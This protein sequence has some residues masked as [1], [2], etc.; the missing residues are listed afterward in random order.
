[1]GAVYRAEQLPLARVCA[2]KVLDPSATRAR[3]LDPAFRRRFLR[4]AAILARLKHP[5]T[6]TLF[7]YGCDGGLCFIAMELVE[8]RTLLELLRSE[9]ALSE[10]RALDIATKVASSLAEAHRAG[11]V[12]RDLKP[13]NVLL[14]TVDRDPDW[15][16]VVDFGLAKPFLATQDE[17][18]TQA[19]VCLGTPRYMA[20][21]QMIHDHVDARSDVYSLGVILFQMLA[22]RAPFDAKTPV[23]ILLSHARDQ[24][25]ALTELSRLVRP[26]T[27]TL[28]A[29]CL[30]RDPADRFSS[31][32]HL[33]DAVNEL[34]RVGSPTMWLGG[35]TRHASL[36]LS[37]AP[38]NEP[39]QPTVRTRPRRRLVSRVV[40]AARLIGVAGAGL[41]VL[42]ALAVSLCVGWPTATRAPGFRVARAPRGLR[43]DVTGARAGERAFARIEEASAEGR[44]VSRVTTKTRESDTP[45][46]FRAR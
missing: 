43:V 38:A 14:T 24:P 21:E 41:A 10:N 26:E 35:R 12:H 25:P 36:P 31:M 22:G 11:I 42:S 37:G 32:A 39:A 13:S 44:A 5:H 16:K 1:M 27:A 3:E 9:G 2:V 6:V 8:G 18:L 17:G 30:A 7:D 15:V 46:I 45:E 28:V 20:P 29:K 34:E 40:A 19:D 33:I 23:S 4:E